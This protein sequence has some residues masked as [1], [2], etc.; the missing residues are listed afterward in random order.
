MANPPIILLNGSSSS[1]KTTLASAIA[2]LADDDWQHMALDQFRDGMAPRLR[3]LNAPD[4]TPGA[5]GLNVVPDLA[6]AEPVTHIRFGATGEQI[7]RGM[8]RA[9]AGF[10]AT[11]NRVI[12]DDLL[13][14]PEYLHDYMQVLSDFPVYFVGV[15]CDRDT[16]QAREA[17][18]TGRFPGTALS[19]FESIHDHGV[20]YDLE[21]DTSHS[22]PAACAAAVLARLATPPRAFAEFAHLAQPTSRI[23]DA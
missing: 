17:A 18:R 20:R 19:H 1:G 7:L 8:R 9:I 2:Q 11:G 13:F 10:A 4:H 15:R 12:V 23:Q 6:G 14:K 3:G 16:V 5:L 21:V 22:Q